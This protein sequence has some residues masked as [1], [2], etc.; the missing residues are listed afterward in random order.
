MM[1]GGNIWTLGLPGDLRCCLLRA[2]A[3][4]ESSGVRICRLLPS[5]RAA[6]KEPLEFER[7]QLN[8]SLIEMAKL[9]K[10]SLMQGMRQNYSRLQMKN[11]AVAAGLVTF[12][13]SVYIYTMKAVGGNDEMEAAIKQFEKEKALKEQGAAS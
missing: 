3:T 7:L 11:F 10:A 9:T 2:T 8:Q 13:G 1:E 4:R 5:A 12:V 6:V